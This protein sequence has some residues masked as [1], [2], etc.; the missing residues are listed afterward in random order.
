MPAYRVL[1]LHVWRVGG[2]G[3]GQTGIS[4]GVFFSPS[5]TQRFLARLPKVGAVGEQGKSICS[6][7][8]ALEMMLRG[9]HCV[10]KSYARIAIRMESIGSFSQG[11]KFY[12]PLMVVL[13]Y[14][15]LHNVLSSTGYE[16]QI[17]QSF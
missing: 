10:I 7:Q 14:S 1:L 11:N 4:D 9:R 5:P 12:N 13:L 2:G 6:S 17:V 8:K 3:G 16:I 15:Q